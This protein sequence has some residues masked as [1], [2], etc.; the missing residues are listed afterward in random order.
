MDMQDE[1]NRSIKR[2]TGNFNFSGE[3]KHTLTFWASEPGSGGRPRTELRSASAGGRRSRRCWCSN[4][5]GSAHTHT[6]THT[7]TRASYRLHSQDA[8]IWPQKIQQLHWDTCSWWCWITTWEF[9]KDVPSVECFT[10]GTK[11]VKSK[12]NHQHTQTSRVSC[13]HAT[14]I[15]KTL[16]AR[17]KCWQSGL[18]MS[19]VLY[20][21]FSSMKSHH[22]H[23]TCLWPFFHTLRFKRSNIC[24]GDNFQ[25]CLI[26]SKPKSNQHIVVSTLSWKV[27]LK[28]HEEELGRRSLDFWTHPYFLSFFLSFFLSLWIEASLLALTSLVPWYPDSWAF[29]K[30][31]RG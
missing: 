8:D 9:F 31:A 30:P 1:N 15:K 6:H 17:I 21:Y 27:N 22:I 26:V 20:W 29:Q 7:H 28:K 2:K 12:K 24:K 5:E 18:Y 4:T 10:F 11:K 3:N 16:G 14:I 23:I 13:L 19:Y 25:P